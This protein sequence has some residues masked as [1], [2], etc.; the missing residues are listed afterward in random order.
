M[1]KLLFVFLFIVSSIA[2]AGEGRRLVTIN[3]ILSF[4]EV[5][6][7]QTASQNII[8]VYVNQTEWTG[9]PSCRNDAADLQAS[10]W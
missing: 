2:I 6:P 1:R 3:K 4:S 9:A 7:A 5:R 8:R 10:D